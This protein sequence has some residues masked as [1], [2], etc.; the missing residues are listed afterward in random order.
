MNT[1]KDI[2]GLPANF[3]HYNTE[4]ETSKTVKIFEISAYFHKPVKVI[5]AIF[6]SCMYDA[7]SYHS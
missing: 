5:Y 7:F 1:Y 6:L 4:A 2:C 3:L